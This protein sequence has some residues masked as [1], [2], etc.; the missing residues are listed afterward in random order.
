MDACDVVSLVFGAPFQ[1][2][3]C[4]FW[5]VSVQDSPRLIHSD[6]ALFGSLQA[7]P[8]WLDR[9]GE[10]IK[11]KKA[12]STQTTSIVNSGAHSLHGLTALADPV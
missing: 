3:N 7:L 8:S 6:A 11:G 10:D 2:W 9:F 5:I 12:L 4:I 1:F